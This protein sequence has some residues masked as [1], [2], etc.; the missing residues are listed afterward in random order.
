MLVRPEFEPATSS[1][2]DQRSPNWA[3]QVG[4]TRYLSL[5]PYNPFFYLNTFSNFS[6]LLQESLCLRCLRKIF[7][8]VPSILTVGKRYN[9]P[10][11]HYCADQSL[12][13]FASTHYFVSFSSTRHVL[14][15][16]D[17]CLWQCFLL[18]LWE[19]SKIFLG[20]ST[21][22][23]Q[24]KWNQSAKREKGKDTSA[25][26]HCAVLSTCSLHC[27]LFE[28]CAEIHYD[29]LKT[30]WGETWH[31][32]ERIDSILWKPL[33]AG[34]C[35]R[36]VQHDIHSLYLTLCGVSKAVPCC[37][38]VMFLSYIPLRD[39]FG[40]S[41][42]VL[43]L[44]IFFHHT[45]IVKLACRGLF[46]HWTLK[47]ARKSSFW[48]EWA[49]SILEALPCFEGCFLM[50]RLFTNTN[51]PLIFWKNLPNMRVALKIT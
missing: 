13:S 34:Q 48:T 22:C 6:F 44:L 35:Q 40:L 4:F 43:Y 14:I 2:A 50:L 7:H 20:S 21:E 37:N 51:S 17:F 47:E 45:W 49:C 33:W 46:Y 5:S 15:L 39:A 42:V 30:S 31:K 41:V 23:S 25:F 32:P 1:S 28:N 29:N 38:A 19:E 27:P 9:G 10:W 16:M 36:I 18:L 11:R 24:L 8:H 3:N 12:P 26:P